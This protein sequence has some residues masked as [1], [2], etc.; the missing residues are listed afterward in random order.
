MA[1]QVSWWSRDQALYRY[2]Q[3]IHCFWHFHNLDLWQLPNSQRIHLLM[4]IY[5]LMLSFGNFRNE[6]TF[7]RNSRAFLQDLPAILKRTRLLLLMFAYWWWR[8]GS[9]NHLILDRYPDLHLTLSLQ[10]AQQCVNGDL[11]LPITYKYHSLRNYKQWT[12]IVH[13][14]ERMV[15]YDINIHVSK[16]LSS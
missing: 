10:V 11:N 1:D 16:R 9:S 2:D 14:S 7:S 15:E 6:E 5:I 12:F 4:I 8:Y 13:N 3:S